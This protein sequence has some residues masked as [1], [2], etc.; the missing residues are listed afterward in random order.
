MLEEKEIIE[1][2][3]SKREKWNPQR[4]GIRIRILFIG[5]SPP[6]QAPQ[7]F[8]YQETAILYR[9]TRKAFI[10]KFKEIPEDKFL[11]FFKKLGCYLYDLFKTPGKKVNK[12]RRTELINAMKQLDD[13][14]QKKREKNEIDAIIVV[15]MRVYNELKKQGL[16]DKWRNKG[17]K[18]FSLPFPI[19]GF[20]RIYVRGLKS[21]LN[22][23]IEQNIIK[24]DEVN[25][26]IEQIKKE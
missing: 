4:Q 8:F 26:I 24:R 5:E 6:R 1:K 22:N 18:I 15:L 14:V 12:V 2:I 7:R 9:A 13:F 16:I 23:L 19:G 17:I 3:E 21:I 11:H 10:Q 25:K 20:Y